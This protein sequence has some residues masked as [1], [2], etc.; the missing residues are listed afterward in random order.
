MGLLSVVGM[1]ESAG[2]AVFPNWLHGK[3]IFRLKAQTPMVIILIS[4]CPFYSWTYKT[5]VSFNNAYYVVA[6]SGCSTCDWYRDQRGAR[7]N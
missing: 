7:A 4:W 2:A 6:C 3:S 1:W 5:F